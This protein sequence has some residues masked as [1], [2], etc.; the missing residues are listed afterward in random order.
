MEHAVL[1]NLKP[2]KKAYAAGL[3]D[4]IGGAGLQNLDLRFEQT[5]R[6][7]DEHLAEHRGKSNE[8]SPKRARQR[9]EEMYEKEPLPEDEVVVF[10]AGESYTLDPDVYDLRATLRYLAFANKLAEPN[11]VHTV[12]WANRDRTANTSGASYWYINPA[13]RI[14]FYRAARNLIKRGM[15]ICCDD[16]GDSQLRFVSMRPDL[17]RKYEAEENG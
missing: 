9:L 13:F 5:N 1:A 15:L 11:P 4:Y 2:A 16:E 7:V 8:P 12:G 14:S 10:Q 3:F 17:E 6:L